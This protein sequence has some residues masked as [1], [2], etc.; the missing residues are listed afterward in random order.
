MLALSIGGGAGVEVVFVTFAYFVH[1]TRI[2]FDFNQVYRMLES[3]LT[4]A[5]Q[6]TEL[7]LEPPTVTDPAE[8]LSL[9]ASDAS[10]RFEQ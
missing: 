10:V 5:A 8:P 9:A 4:E 7:I 3:S 1:A 6:F 2:V